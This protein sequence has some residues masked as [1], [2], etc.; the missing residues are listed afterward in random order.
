MPDDSSFDP[1]KPAQPKIPG[2]PAAT[3]AEPEP[4]LEAE[5]SP[6]PPPRRLSVK[7]IAGGLG[8]A[9][10][11]GLVLAWIF[12]RPSGELEDEAG[13]APQAS[14]GAASPAAGSAPQ[15]PAAP[16]ASLP[17]AP[18]E[19]VA[20]TAELSQPWM[21][22]RFYFRNAAGQ[23]VPAMLVRLPGGSGRT[24]AGYWAF[25]TKP[26]LATS[27]CELELVSDAQRLREEFGQRGTQPMV[28]DACSSTIYNPLAY[29]N[30]RGAM[31][32]GDVV[33][34]PGFRPPILIE[35]RVT[36]NQVFATQIEE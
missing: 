27:R 8:G 15:T 4:P 36:G 32:R 35:V 13:T 34:G 30:V 21:S 19:A 18:R 6:P 22:K 29:G 2:V 7:W 10:L 23:M 33:R 24:A 25:S 16:A 1:F 5:A 9:L 17:V 11:L 20:T 3:P 12:L 14:P 26:P 31:V 28:V